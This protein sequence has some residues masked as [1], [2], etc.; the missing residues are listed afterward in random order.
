MPVIFVFLDGVGLAPTSPHNPLATAATPTLQQLLGGPLTQEQIQQ[1]P[2]LLLR[3][4]DTTLG[5]PG[6]PQSGT[7]QTALLT[8]VNAPALVGRHQPYYP[9]VALRPLLAERSIF[10]QVQ[11]RGLRA[12]FAN[13]FTPGYWQAL[14]DRRLRRTAGVIA[15]EGAGLRLRNLDD[16][17]AGHALMWDI[18]HALLS[19]RDP[20]LNI[21]VIAAQLAGER[22]AALAHTHDLVFFE[23]FLPDLA[24]HGRLPVSVADV[25]EWIDGLLAGLLAALRPQDTLLLTSDHGNIEDCTAAGH[26]YNPVPLLVVGAAARHFATVQDSTGV[27]AGIIAALSS[28]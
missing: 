19:R 24:G 4:I 7:G 13:A 18:T 5:V 12:T 27:A 1:Q 15:A 20:A 11:T 26:T 17:R 28:P 16:L 2:A 23:C 3:A 21:P 25:L 8:G 9:P 6:L 22:L 14:A 10:H